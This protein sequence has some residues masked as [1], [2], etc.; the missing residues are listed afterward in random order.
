M[1]KTKRFPRREK[2]VALQ[3]NDRESGAPLLIAKGEGSLAR[4]IKE[5]AAAGGIPVKRDDDLVEL[6]AQVEI[7]REIPPELFATVAEILAWVYRANE[8]IKR[9]D[10]GDEL[11]R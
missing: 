11:S 3:Y 8:T 5:L 2:A 10:L 4:R 9:R 1:A 7:N 6:L